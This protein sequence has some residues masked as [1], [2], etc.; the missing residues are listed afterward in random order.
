MWPIK[1]SSHIWKWTEQKDKMNH[2]DDDDDDGDGNGDHD[3][4]SEPLELWVRNK[5]LWASCVWPLHG[6]NDRLWGN[7]KRP[8]REHLRFFQP[9]TF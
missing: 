9:F 1:T 5:A 4:D 8:G 6:K 2:D 7:E 3:D